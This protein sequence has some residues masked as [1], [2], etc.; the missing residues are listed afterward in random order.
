MLQYPNYFVT[1]HHCARLES[2]FPPHEWKTSTMFHMQKLPAYSTMYT[3]SRIVS[4]SEVITMRRRAPGF[5]PGLMTDMYHPDSAYVSWRTGLNG[6][7][8]FDLYTRSAP[9]GGAYLLVAGLEAAM[10]FVQAFHYTPDE[11]KFLS[12]I[13]DYDAAFL[14]ELA[15]LR[16]TGEIF[17]LPEGS[18]AFPNEPIMQVPAPFRDPLLL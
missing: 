1:S 3:N 9:F 5:H 11:I 6:L 12:H 4:L 8:T 14:D 10:E 15:S 7:T 18:S 16:F 2:L 13:R 17:A